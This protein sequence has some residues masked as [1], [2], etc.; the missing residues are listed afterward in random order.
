[1][2]LHQPTLAAALA[3]VTL[4]GAACADDV[5]VDANAVADDVIVD[6][7]ALAVSVD[8]DVGV[9]GVIVAFTL[10]SD[11]TGCAAA[12]RCAVRFGDVDA[13]IAADYGAVYAVVP[14]GAESGPA[15]V[16]LDGA[17]GCV[18]YTIARAPTLVSATLVEAECI[19]RCS[20]PT[21]NSVALVGTALPSDGVIVVDGVDHP[22][23]FV[24]SSTSAT[25]DLDTPLAP[26]AHT[27]HVRAPSHG[28]TTSNALSVSSAANSAADTGG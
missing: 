10:P 24:S 28:G 16:T 25:V 7:D 26:G 23:A 22:G 21:N 13:A 14:A 8:G 20:G 17:A 3:L 4:A 12:G 27:I 1:M 18:D 2:H 9:A 6:A 5:V 15:C 11:P 19:C